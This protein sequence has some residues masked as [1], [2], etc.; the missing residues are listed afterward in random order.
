MP[1]F[2]F[3]AVDQKGKEIS[4][5]VEA[6]SQD[7]ATA[8]IREKGLFPTSVTD[9]AA[10]GTGKPAGPA[11]RKKAAPAQGS[12]L[13]KDLEM[14]K[15][16]QR[17]KPKQ[18]MAFTRQLATLV[19]AG[20]PLVRGLK[21]LGRQERNPMLRDAL[22]DMSDAIESG[23]NFAEALVQHPRI[24]D[25]LYV[26]MVKAGEVGGV[27]DKVLVSL[28]E[29]MEKI[30][31]IKNKVVGA[32][33]YPIVVL[34]LA[35]LILIFLMLFIIPRFE[36]IFA[37][38]MN[39]KPLPLL[40]RFVVSISENFAK[41]G[42][43]LLGVV[44]LLGIGLHF[45]KKS[46]KGGYAIDKVKLKMPLF[47]PLFMKSAIARF[48]RTLGELMDSGVPVLQ[49]LTIVGETSGNLV[50]SR[51]VRVVHDAV[52]EGENIAPT[53]AST[54]IFPPVVIS[55]V[56]VG[57]ETGEL[58]QML[59]RIANNYDDEVDNA[60]AGLTSVIEPLM[61]VMLA[62]IVGTI[63]I[64]LFLPLIEIINGLNTG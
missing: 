63:V 24:F 12:S 15:F 23:S 4:G 18:L 17:V 7:A 39:D 40:T 32:M 52:K 26:N 31:K 14:P 20:L 2:R 58:P 53:L 48:T 60:V 30:Q 8:I 47:G 49:A 54:G 50:V 21:V 33:V 61:I 56:E 59:R 38:I 62:V 55:M 42:P 36:K 43:A 46:E 25:K 10:S 41:L 51:A 22:T 29:F 44:I 6:A 45:A 1:K 37:D 5:S 3:I 13:K 9:A 28:A 27:L 57:E 34:F 16:M 11:A 19:N 64:A 35:T